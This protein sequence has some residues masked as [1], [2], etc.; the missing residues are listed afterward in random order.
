MSHSVSPKKTVPN[1]PLHSLRLRQARLARGLTLEEVSRLVSINK[2]TLQRYESGDIR[3]IAPERLSRLADLYG[4]TCAW[5]YGASEQ[6]EFTDADGIQIVPIRAD[7]PT[8][9]GH[10]LQACLRFL[11]RQENKSS[12]KG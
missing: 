7:S 3:T 2:M 6:Q 10:R 5:L 1:I 8:H 9:L 4:T 12:Y 11:S